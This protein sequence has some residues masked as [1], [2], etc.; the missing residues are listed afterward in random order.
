MSGADPTPSPV[1]L[2]AEN[3]AL[4]AKVERYEA[5]RDVSAKS[6]PVRSVA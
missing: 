3:E 4:R 6:V 1:D 2:L 5:E